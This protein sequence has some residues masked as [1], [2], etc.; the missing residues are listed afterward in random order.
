M[1]MQS[2][3]K[4]RHD[5]YMQP[6]LERI[7]GYDDVRA[8]AIIRRAH[9]GVT[10]ELMNDLDRRDVL[11]LDR[12]GILLA[13]GIAEVRHEGDPRDLMIGLA[14]HYVVAQQLGQSPPALFNDVAARLPDGSVAE[15]FREFGARKD[16]TLKAFGWQ[17]VQ[18][19]NGPD[20]SPA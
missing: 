1:P 9:D 19:A 4:V 2:S 15:L 18:T 14:L 5:D 8:E 16:I 13:T 7:P 6:N 10:A 17:L 20:L 11:A 3:L 12:Y